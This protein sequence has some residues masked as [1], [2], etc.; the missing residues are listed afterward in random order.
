[1]DILVQEKEEVPGEED[2]G[3]DNS[4]DTNGDGTAFN[5]EASAA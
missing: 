2:G 4:E 3:D 1:V 5:W